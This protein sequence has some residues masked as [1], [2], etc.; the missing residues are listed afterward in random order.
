MVGKLGFE[1]RMR[2]LWRWTTVVVYFVEKRGRGELE[3]GRLSVS[4][5]VPKRFFK[6]T[7]TIIF[8]FLE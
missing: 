2:D 8:F 7:M 4:T 5:D 6:F 1:M 3:A